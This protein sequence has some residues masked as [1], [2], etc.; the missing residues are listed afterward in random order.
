MRVMGISAST[1]NINCKDRKMA[2]SSAQSVGAW[3]EN[4]A[5]D[6]VG[7]WLQLD[8]Q[9]LRRVNPGVRVINEQINLI[10]YLKFIS[11]RPQTVLGG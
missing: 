7:G 6:R 11:T 1:G 5:E 2:K 9:L 3:V 4:G 8:V 10:G